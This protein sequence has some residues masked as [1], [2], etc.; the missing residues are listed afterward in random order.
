MQKVCADTCISMFSFNA[1][2]QLVNYK[3]NPEV[4]INI[5]LVYSEL[6]RPWDSKPAELY[7]MHIPQKQ[8]HIRFYNLIL[9]SALNKERKNYIYM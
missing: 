8:I 7:S 5:V 3:Q 1:V 4:V 2:S 9:Y 6:D